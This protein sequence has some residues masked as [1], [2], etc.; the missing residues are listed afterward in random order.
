ML[1]DSDA[2]PRRFA[3]LSL[4]KF[5]KQAEPAVPALRKALEDPKPEVR[6]AASN[7]MVAIGGQAIVPAVK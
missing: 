1:Q 6:E 5:G 4:G 7:S 2:Y 3:A